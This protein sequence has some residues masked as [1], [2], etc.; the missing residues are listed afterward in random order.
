[1]SEIKTILNFFDKNNGLD[2]I[3]KDLKVIKELTT[4]IN[5][6]KVQLT[7]PELS[8]RLDA[9][10]K[11]TRLEKQLAAER[12]KQ[13]KAQQKVNDERKESLGLLGKQRQEV[14]RLRKAQKFAQTEEELKDIN[15][16]LL[17]ATRNVRKFGQAGKESTNTFGAAIKSFGF[18]FN[19]LSDIISGAGFA[20]TAGFKNALVG[21]VEIFKDFE[22]ANANLAAVLGK[23]IDQ[24]QALQDSAKQLG[25]TTAFTASQV[26]ELQTEFA[27]LGFTEQEILNVTGATLDLAA[28]AGTDLAN[29]ASITGSTLRAFGLDATE[30]GRVADVMAK[31]FSISSLDIEK[32]STAM[33]N[34][35][36]VAASAGVSVEETTALLGTLTDAGLDAS[37]AG[38]GLRNVFLEISKQGITLEDALSQIQN[39][40]DKNAVSLD[41]F[42]KRGA[43]IGTVLANTTDKAK[44]LTEALN[45][46]GGFAQATAETQLDTL[47]GSLTKL[48]SAWEGFILSLE[49]GQGTL[50]KTVRGIID[51]VT[52]IF[53]LLSGAAKA[54]E[55]LNDTEKALR[56]TANA[57]VNVGK[58]LAILVTSFASY[59]VAVV[60]SN[61]ATKA[62]AAAQAAYSTVVGL[63]TGKIK[64]ATVA[65]RVFNTVTKL[66][67]IGLLVT[68]LTA[69]ASA[70]L[71]FRDNED[72]ATESTQ[73]FTKAQ[74]DAEKAIRTRL[75]SLARTRKIFDK[76]LKDQNA[77]LRDFKEAELEA[78][79]AEAVR[80]AER[81]KSVGERQVAIRIIRRIQA[82]EKRREEERNAIL[83]ENTKKKKKNTKATR[84]LVG[85][86]ELQT[87]KIRNIKEAIQQ[88][89]DEE[90]IL[91]LRID[92]ANAEDELQRLNDLQTESIKLKKTD[93][94]TV[95]DLNSTQ[96]KAFEERMKRREQEIADKEAKRKSEE[97]AEKE[98]AERRK[99]ITKDIAENSEKLVDFQIANLR[100]EAE[101][102]IDSL[103]RQ[104]Q[105]ENEFI[106]QNEN[107][108]AE[109]IEFRRKKAAE[110]EAERIQEQKRLEKL[111][112]TEAFFELVTAF[113]KEGDGLAAIGKATAAIATAEAA[114]AGFHDG[115]YTGDGNEYDSAGI[116][117][118]GEF[119]N[120]KKQTSEYGMKGWTAKDFDKAVDE[121]YF[122]QFSNSGL[123]ADQNAKFL[124]VQNAEIGYDF[125]QLESKLD[126]V[127]N[128]V[129]NSPTTDFEING[130]YFIK[131]TKR[132]GSTTIKKRKLG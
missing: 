113:A 47:T 19:L 87:E 44:D 59:R 109:E 99:E 88:A 51:V 110:L 46:A 114:T 75:V 27:K 48:S 17:Q 68:A 127:V 61:I 98:A 118:K 33:A 116:V 28:A 22:Q 96:Q 84:E 60:A 5:K 50:A 39:A 2:G 85:L 86:I 54:E 95:K 64:L 78:A 72:E 90:Q 80:R 130:E 69:A 12:K 43:V 125:K 49:D 11:I 82:E 111:A 1:M 124:S 71:L 8:K 120:T 104:I 83:D 132:N 131:K 6:Q 62:A 89:T 67:P 24:T 45:E 56:D 106:N 102:R 32:F 63:V 65:M 117:H 29:A 14:L 36:P 31:S 122:N 57:V 40:S 93:E 79:K 76:L 7:S 37:T 74:Y 34:V 25:A 123:F 3:I 129:N 115:G 30:A 70:F 94:I 101:A 112:K 126:S 23:T 55:Q 20:I 92:L 15:R 77:D 26:T 103:D 58:V 66:N 100:R 35:A 108:S 38:T 18:K 119:V 10:S 41:L 42:G 21:T 105:A 91:R 107:L 9:I 52:E 97:K 121:G 53:S 13:I 16:Q 81:A 73:R 4:A 128:A